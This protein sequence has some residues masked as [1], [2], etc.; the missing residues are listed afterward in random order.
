[1]NHLMGMANP[2][3]MLIKGIYDHVQTG[4]KVNRSLDGMSLFDEGM[5]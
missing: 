1:M 5:R 3:N 2:K 4:R